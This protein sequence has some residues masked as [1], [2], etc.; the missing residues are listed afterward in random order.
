MDSEALAPTPAGC[1]TAE[2]EAQFVASATDLW[3]TPWHNVK[4]VELL[5]LLRAFQTH[6]ATSWK[7]GQGWP[8]ASFSWVWGSEGDRASITHTPAAMLNTTPRPC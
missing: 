1:L 7:G 5:R 4:V 2:Q 8:R 6:P 3:D